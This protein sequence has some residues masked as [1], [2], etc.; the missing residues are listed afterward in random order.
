L[1]EKKMRGLNRLNEFRDALEYLPI[2]TEV[3][4]KAAEL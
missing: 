4:L 2:T 3:M 1:R